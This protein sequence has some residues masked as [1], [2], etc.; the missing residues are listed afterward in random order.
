MAKNPAYDHYM[1]AGDAE[2]NHAKT[3]KSCSGSRRCA[4]GQQLWTAFEKAQD[5]HMS[6][7]WPQPGRR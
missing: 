2:R 1:R 4:V 5:A 6:S 7:P 3:C